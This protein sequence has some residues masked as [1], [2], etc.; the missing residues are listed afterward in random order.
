MKAT[1]R[2]IDTTERVHEQRVS[3]G[4]DG[5]ATHANGVAQPELGAP[6]PG[7]GVPQRDLGAPQPGPGAP[8]SSPLAKRLLDGPGWTRLRV[9]TDLALL[10]LAVAAAL[11][12]GASADLS[13]AGQPLMWVF[14]PVALALLAL[15]GTY[16]PGIKP[17]RFQ[18]VWQVA[19]ATSLAAMVMIVL[20]AFAAG[21]PNFTSLMGRAWF[22]GTVYVVAG[23]MVLARVQRLARLD[24]AAGERTLIVGAGR[25]GAQVER[26]LIENPTL[27]LHP[28]GFLDADPP[29]VALV[30]ATSRSVLGPP[31]QLIEVARA[32]GAEHVIFAF[33]AEPDHKLVPLVRLCHANGLRATVIPR[34][35]EEVTVRT[36][37][38]HI[39]GLPLSNLRFVGPHS[40]RF[41]VKH[42]LD[43]LVAMALTVLTSPVLLGAA[44]AIKATSRGPVFFRQRRVG[45]D[46][47]EFT[48]IKFRTME[49]DP[50]ADGEANA[51]WAAAA[52]GEAGLVVPVRRTTR[53]G[54][55]LRRYSIDELPQLFNILAGHMSLVGPRPEVPHYVER[56]TE[57]IP[58]YRDRLRVKPGLTGWAQVHDFELKTP[59]VDRVEWDNYYIENW[60]M[61]LDLQILLMTVGVLRGRPAEGLQ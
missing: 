20:N 19:G 61:A 13:L 3:R 40:W 49:G 2:S 35:F 28:V 24:G 59:L 29:P 58:R 1:R 15:H 21:T 14:V 26:R 37:L 51:A 42:G 23:R 18:L 33:A 39:V 54:R 57:H 52:V 9:A 34:L 4:A 5:S 60:S 43:R 31:S 8:Q 16:S 46:G 27:G 11:I 12:G 48:M 55:F 53:V 45:R 22:F 10:L 36:G 47:Q 44:L 17:R 6:Q 30:G 56:F 38:E 41:T 32:T 25:I 50:S 7:P